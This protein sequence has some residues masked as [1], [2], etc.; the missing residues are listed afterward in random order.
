MI[1]Q[2]LILF[3]VITMFVASLYLAVVA[4]LSAWRSASLEGLSSVENEIAQLEA[5]VAT[6]TIGQQSF[7]SDDLSGLTWEAAQMAEA[8]A[9][10]QSA[11]N[12]TARENGIVL[13]SIAPASGSETEIESAIGF[14][15]EFEAHLD[16]LVPF[17]K[18]VEFGQPALVVTR[19]N[20]RRLSRP[21]QSNPQPELFVQIELAAPVTL[22]DEGEG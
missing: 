3:S 8:T 7:V 20:L 12:D 18:A 13:R 19:A 14:R 15:L 11:V 10:V 16:Q 5:R 21:N 4:P 9:I 2:R 22:T 6:L 17:L 1:R